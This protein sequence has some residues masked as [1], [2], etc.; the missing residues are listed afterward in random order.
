MLLLLPARQLYGE[1]LYCEWYQKYVL[2]PKTAHLTC[3]NYLAR[4]KCA[5]KYLAIV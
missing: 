2:Y 3:A 1:F 4:H 5:Q